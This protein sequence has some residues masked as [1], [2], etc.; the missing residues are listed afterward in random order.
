MYRSTEAFL[1]IIK[2]K[3]GHSEARESGKSIA[4]GALIPDITM[5]ETELKYY[6]QSFFVL[7][8]ESYT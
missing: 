3:D 4:Y 6:F 2:R 1:L 8:I 7:I 5:I